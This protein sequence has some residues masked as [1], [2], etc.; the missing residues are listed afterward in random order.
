MAWRWFGITTN[1][2]TSVPGYRSPNVRND[3]ATASPS[4]F[5]SLFVPTTAPKIV[6]LNAAWIV[7]KN[8]PCE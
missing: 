3:S 4:T 6:L 5:S 8:V 1:S 2:M 7:T